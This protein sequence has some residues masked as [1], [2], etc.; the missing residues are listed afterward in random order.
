MVT[1]GFVWMVDYMA[2]EAL[3]HVGVNE[4][5]GAPVKADLATRNMEQICL[6]LRTYPVSLRIT[7]PNPEAGPGWLL[8]SGCPKSVVKPDRWISLQFAPEWLARSQWEDP[9]T[10]T[11]PTVAEVTAATAKPTR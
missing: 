10:W 3:P 1:M 4:A 7:G 6:Y 11:Y 9:S 8:D 2:M 5:F